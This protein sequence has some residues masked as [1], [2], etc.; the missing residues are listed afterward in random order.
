MLFAGVH[1]DDAN[2]DLPMKAAEPES[3][4]Q[5]KRL[6]DQIAASVLSGEFQPGLRLDEHMLAE[7]FGVSRA[8]AREAFRQLAS[9]G[10][11]EISQSCRDRRKRHFG[12]ARYAVLC[13][14]RA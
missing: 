9:T 7:R 5:A 11:I 10:L 1:K 14:G 2:G 8:P 4:T 13:D 12:A 6:A 3:S